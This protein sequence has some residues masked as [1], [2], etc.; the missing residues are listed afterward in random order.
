MLYVVSDPSSNVTTTKA[1]YHMTFYGFNSRSNNLRDRGAFVI[2]LTLGEILTHMRR[3]ATYPSTM[4][5]AIV[6]VKNAKFTLFSKDQMCLRTIVSILGSY[7][8]LMCWGVCVFI[9][10]LA[11]HI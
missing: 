10:R 8:F 4:H 7:V 5:G 2:M 3:V 9:Q 11:Q 6:T 1:T